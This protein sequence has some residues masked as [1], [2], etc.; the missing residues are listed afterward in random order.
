[1]RRKDREIT[2]FMQIETIIREAN[3]CR[4]GMSDTSHQPYVVPMC[5]GYSNGTVYFHSASEGRKIAILQKNPQ[6]CIEFDTNC[7]IKT[8]DI[9]CRWGFRYQCVIGF[10]KAVFIESLQE[11]Q[12]ALD[13]IMKQYSDGAFTYSD[14]ALS[15]MVTFKVKLT[16]ISGKTA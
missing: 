2:D 8:G 10:G 16:E 4:L 1:M 9:A 5:F 11:K 6:V 14:D 13:I 15:R 3:F 12:I 7:H